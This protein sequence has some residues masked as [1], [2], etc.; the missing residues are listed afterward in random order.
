MHWLERDLHLI[1]MMS[2]F[3]SYISRLLRIIMSTYPKWQLQLPF[4][5]GCGHRIL[6]LIQHSS[7]MIIMMSPKW[8]ILT[9]FNTA[10]YRILANLCNILKNVLKMSKLMDI[11][12]FFSASTLK[13]FVICKAKYQNITHTLTSLAITHV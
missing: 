7:L 5:E 2:V 13:C 1:I 10:N 11:S 12:I 9:H 4:Y 8:K 6:S 3:L